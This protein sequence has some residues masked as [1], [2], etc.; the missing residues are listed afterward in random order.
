[1]GK[2][3]TPTSDSSDSFERYQHAPET[4]A[5]DE[6]PRPVDGV[7]DP[8]PS[9]RPRFA[10]AFL[11][12]DPIVGK[13]PLD[14]LADEA[15]VLLVGD[16]HGRCVRLD[17]GGD[18]V[19][20]DS[21]RIRAREFGHAPGELHF[22]VIVHGL[23]RL[24]VGSPSS[25]L[26]AASMSSAPSSWPPLCQCSETEAPAVSNIDD[27]WRVFAAGTIVSL[28][29]ALRNIETALRSGSVSG[30]NGT[31]ARKRT[32][33]KRCRGS[34]SSRLAAILAPLEYPIAMS[35]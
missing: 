1:M 26:L 11:P 29:P 15:L 33:A 17:L 25:Q 21:Y 22:C 31:I 4:I 20:A 27:N 34:R 28:C 23:E 19:S 9:A 16:R 32:A 7:D 5:A 24:S 2:C 30:T 3:A 12:E 35:F 8:A 14:R 10:R 13:I 6:V 18:P